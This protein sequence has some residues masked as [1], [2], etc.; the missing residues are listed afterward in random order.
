MQDALFLLSKLFWLFARP[1]TFALMLACLG[2]GTLIAGRRWG[3]WPLL[4]GLG[5][6]VAVL[7]TPLAAWVSLPL[8]D[9]FARPEAPAR[10]D[11]VIILGGA[12]EQLLTE[13]RGIP[14]LNGAAERMTEAVALSRRYPEARILFTG[15]S[16][17]PL[18]GAITEAEVARRLFASLGLEGERVLLEAQSRNTWENATMTRAMIPPRPG[19]TW[20]LVTSASHMPRSMGCFRRAGWEVVAWPVNYS[21]LRGGAG[22]FDPPW[23]FRLGQAE[24]AIR[25][26][27]GLVAYRLLGRTDA[28]FPV[29]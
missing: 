21:T 1:N 19:E 12:V 29:P 20:L 26:Y 15:G 9:R 28:L 13:S 27:V 22:W 8:E 18:P 14:S 2:A 5:W 16:G 23:S 25:E 6:F 3:R 17:N 24:W 10:V 11:G 7:V 4:L